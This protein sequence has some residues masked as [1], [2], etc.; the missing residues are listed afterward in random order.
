MG[1]IVYIGQGGSDQSSVHY[2][3]INYIEI[4]V[5]SKAFSSE[6]PLHNSIW[7]QE[8]SQPKEAS[9]DCAHCPFIRQGNRW[10]G[11]YLSL[12]EG[13]RGMTVKL[14]FFSTSRWGGISTCQHRLTSRLPSQALIFRVACSFSTKTKERSWS[15]KRI[16]DTSRPLSWGS[17][18]WN[19]C[20]S[21]CWPQI[22]SVSK[23]SVP[24]ASS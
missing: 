15:E 16:W 21:S 10:Q 24:A 1:N 8:F 6:I 17:W 11:V 2:N 18:L 13:F 14:M 4:Q 22:S 3:T 23:L 19:T 12:L 20:S 5:S 9:R 7:L